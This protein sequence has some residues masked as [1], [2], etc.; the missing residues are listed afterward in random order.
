MD[1]L[2]PCTGRRAA[3]ARL[4]RPIARVLVPAI[5]ALALWGLAPAVANAQ[6][7]WRLNGTQLGGPLGTSWSGKVKVTDAKTVA[8]ALSL[9]CEDTVEGSSGMAGFGEVTK[10]TASKCGAAK[11]CESGASNTIEPL[12]LPWYSELV[13]VEGTI[14]D[15]VRSSGNGTPGLAVHCKV[16]GVKMVDECSGTLSLNTKNTESGVSATFNAGEK[17][18]CTDSEPGAGSVEGGQSLTATG[19]GKLSAESEAERRPVWLEGGKEFAGGKEIGWTGTITLKDMVPTAG[20]LA[21]SCQESGIGVA[22]GPSGPS[23]GSVSSL[24]LSSCVN[25]SGSNCEAAGGY[26]IKALN[27]SWDTELGASG[28]AVRNAFT[29][30]GKG[31][32]GFVLKCRALGVTFEDECDVV[33]STIMTNTTSGVTA[34]F[35]NRRFTCSLGKAEAGQLEGSQTIKLT[36]EGLLHVS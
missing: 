5:G 18:N 35:E 16:V 22:G 13:T 24:T 1:A 23:V 14:R 17:L 19:G 9:E 10:L 15:V 30:S 26:S 11:V 33:P 4:A 21:V 7:G 36:K 20:E 2:E 12:N 25:A 3:R 29:S 28:G 27:L 32:P 8:G 31:T 34:A 6:D